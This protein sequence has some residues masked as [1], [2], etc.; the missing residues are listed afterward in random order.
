[1][2]RRSDGRVCGG[3]WTSEDEVGSRAVGAGEWSWR[4]VRPTEA[5]WPCRGGER[6]SPPP[7]L[8]SSPLPPLPTSSPPPH[9]SAPCW[10]VYP[11]GKLREEA[12]PC[13]PPHVSPVGC[14]NLHS[15]P[16]PP[17]ESVKKGH[18][19]DADGVCAVGGSADEW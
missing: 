8:L 9:C 4:V 15:H 12:F 7:A 11:M 1:M 18:R 17:W 13:P 19:G 5:S 10:A 14:L 3:R 2:W 16:W 6:E